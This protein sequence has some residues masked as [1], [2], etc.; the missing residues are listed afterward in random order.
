M[1]TLIGCVATRDVDHKSEVIISSQ[2]IPT[3]C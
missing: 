2:F 1:V 3:S